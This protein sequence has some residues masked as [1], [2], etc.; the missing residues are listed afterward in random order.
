MTQKIIARPTIANVDIT[1]ANT[2]YSYELP[3]GTTRFLIKV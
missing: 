1:D 3:A 2:E